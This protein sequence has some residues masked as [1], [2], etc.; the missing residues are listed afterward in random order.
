[1]NQFITHQIKASIEAKQAILA[2]AAMI[3]TIQQVAAA[4]I[5]AYRNGHKLLLAGN[6]GSAGDAQHIAGEMVNRFR[7][8]RPALPAISLATD[9]SVLTAIGNDSSFEQVFA[10]QVEALGV[11][12]DMFIG[13]STSGKSPNIIR[14]LQV[15]GKKGIIRVGF[16]G[17]AGGEMS[18]HC[19]YCIAVPSRETP[20]IQEAHILIAHIF[21]ALVEED[22]FGKG[23]AT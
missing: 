12:G 2:D 13:I 19:D 16:T 14:A 5:K 18:S 10:R 9:T 17:Q 21:C 20:R 8:D 1:M 11:A 22:L 4:A 15:C 7:F 23:F 6:G 3:G